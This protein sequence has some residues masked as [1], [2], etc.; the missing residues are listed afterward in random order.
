MGRAKGENK[1]L[2]SFRFKEALMK[3]L[4]DYAEKSG[5]SRTD[6]IEA[7]LAQCLGAVVE[8]LYQERDAKFHRSISSSSPAS[9]GDEGAVA[10]VKVA[11][12][13]GRGRK[14]KAGGPNAAASSPSDTSPVA[15]SGRQSPPARGRE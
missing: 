14:R 4:D 15:Q 6:I 12:S 8:K 9:T 3:R 13:S 5:F 10:A 2:K 1:I 7:A 11:A